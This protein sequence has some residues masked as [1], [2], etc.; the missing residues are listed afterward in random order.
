MKHLP[1]ILKLLAL[2]ITFFIFNATSLAVT[3]PREIYQVFSPEVS[4]FTRYGTYPVS[5]Y[6]GQPDISIP[7]YTVKSGDY[8]IPISLKYDASGFRPNNPDGLIGQNW[9]LTGIGMITRQVRGI[10][11]DAIPNTSYAPYPSGFLKLARDNNLAS[12]NALLSIGD[13]FVGPYNGLMFLTING[14]NYASYEPDLFTVYLPNGSSFQFMIDNNGT[15]QVLGHRNCK[16]NLDSVNIQMPETEVLR[17]KITI[18]DENGYKYIFGGDLSKM[19]VSYNLNYYT[20]NITYYTQLDTYKA[21]INAWYISTIVSPYNETLATYEYTQTPVDIST[22]YPH[23]RKNFSLSLSVTPTTDKEYEN[24]YITKLAIPTCIKTTNNKIIFEK[25]TPANYFY[26]HK[27]RCISR[28]DGDPYNFGTRNYK[29]DFKNSTYLI[30]KISITDY[31][32][33]L[34]IPLSYTES[35]AIENSDTTYRHFLNKI[36]IGEKEIQ[37]S[38]YNTVNLPTAFTQKLDMQGYYNGTSNTLFPHTN[39]DNWSL[40]RTTNPTYANMGMLKSITYPTGGSTTFDFE[41][42]KYGKKVCRKKDG[43]IGEQIIT[44]S[45]Y[46]GGTRIKKITNSDGTVTDFTYTDNSIDSGIFYDTD[47]Y[48]FEYETSIPSGCESYGVFSNSISPQVDL[49][50]HYIGYSTVK[51]STHQENTSNSL[52]KSYT[53]TNRITNPDIAYISNNNIKIES[54]AVTDQTSFNAQVNK[55]LVYSS[56]GME[57]GLLTS[58]SY[59]SGSSLI[60]QTTHEYNYSSSLLSQFIV[61]AT[62]ILNWCSAGAANSYATYLYDYDKVVS[63]TRTLAGSTWIEEKTVTERGGMTASTPHN[64][65]T[66]QTRLTSSGDSTYTIYKR[67]LD[68]GIMTTYSGEQAKGIYYLQQQN[69]VSPIIEEATFL[70]KT[71][72]GSTSTYLIESTITDYR[73]EYNAPVPKYIYKTKLTT[74]RLFSQYTPSNVSGNSF[75]YQSDIFYTHTSFDMY[76]PAGK[77]LQYTD[78]NGISTSYIWGYSNQRLLAIVVGD[79]YTNFSNYWGGSQGAMIMNYRGA[80]RFPTPEYLLSV[81]NLRNQISALVTTYTHSPLFGVTSITNPMGLTT[82]YDYYPTGEL[83]K[84]YRLKNVT[85]GNSQVIKAYNYKYQELAQ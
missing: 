62:Q 30:S 68:Y 2:I 4:T 10:P 16:I 40:I 43:T 52:I 67:P 14:V 7:I 56:K 74:P 13:L 58:E 45:G 42:H 51:E 19:E 9:S 11:D 20:N 41:S 49:G 82:Y 33:T 12:K 39:P 66:K 79:K 75:S 69:R 63:T 72:S 29:N 3:D 81:N 71:A 80:D 44:G 84:E 26:S 31:L 34:N 6:T 18:I 28:F 24:V 38:Y 22:D 17:S 36:N 61:G 55:L 73:Y 47:V 15:P 25:T 83:K 50:E 23:L 37:F 21:T 76:N 78:H 27:L 53:Y 48:Y 5:Y 70:K 57:R 64:F 8:E 65:I 35:C 1:H 32:D 60:K 77:L 54:N 46:V 59:Y 85:S